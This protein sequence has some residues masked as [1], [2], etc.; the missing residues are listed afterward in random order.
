[1]IAHPLR[2]SHVTL[3][4]INLLHAAFLPFFC[5]VFLNPNNSHR[6]DAL[7]PILPFFSLFLVVGRSQRT[8]VGPQVP[9]ERGVAGEGAVALAADVAA[10]PGVHLHVLLQGALRLE[11]LPAQQAEHGHVRTCQR[12]RDTAE[13]SPRTP[14]PPPPSS[15]SPLAAGM[16]LQQ[17][18]PRELRGLGITGTVAT[19]T[20]S[21]LAPQGECQRRVGGSYCC[22]GRWEPQPC[23]A[24]TRGS[25]G[26]ITASPHTCESCRAQTL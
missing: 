20:L 25:C 18:G 17:E 21:S 9:L 14:V 13:A 4:R 5:L 22:R 1:M 3:Y 7:K 26:A 2:R 11:P 15:G 16:L 24:Q 8:C 6:L 10:H 19:P 12:N 23:D